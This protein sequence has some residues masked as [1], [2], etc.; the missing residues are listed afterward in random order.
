MNE[1]NKAENSLKGF[2]DVSMIVFILSLKVR[3]VY[4]KMMIS[5]KGFDEGSPT[6]EEW[7]MQQGRVVDIIEDDGFGSNRRTAR[8]LKPFF[9]IKGFDV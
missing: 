8:Q 7:M 2:H 9:T 5:E 4:E 6:G 3:E 1:T